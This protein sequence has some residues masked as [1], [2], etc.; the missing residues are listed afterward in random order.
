ME[1]EDI[2]IIQIQ[3]HQSYVDILNGKGNL[4]IQSLKTIKNKKI[5]VEIAKE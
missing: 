2:G 5:K 1:F 3:N 4:V